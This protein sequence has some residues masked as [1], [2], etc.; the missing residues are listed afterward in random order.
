MTFPFEKRTTYTIRCD[1]CGFQESFDSKSIRLLRI[2]ASKKGWTIGNKL[3]CPDCKAD[4]TISMY[5]K[6]VVSVLRE[7]AMTTNQITAML[8]EKPNSQRR[9]TVANALRRM[10]DN[11]QI[12]S[13]TAA[14]GNTYWVLVE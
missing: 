2:D 9:R 5:G 7:G 12:V 13:F 1:K 11:E 6:K 14:D 3:K 10:V 4:R 8:Y